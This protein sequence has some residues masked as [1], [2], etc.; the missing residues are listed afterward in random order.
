[1]DE[2]LKKEGLRRRRRMDVAEPKGGC[3]K[4]VITHETF[5]LGNYPSSSV[6]SMAL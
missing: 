2:F 6:Y 1:M 4:D 3:L 5:A